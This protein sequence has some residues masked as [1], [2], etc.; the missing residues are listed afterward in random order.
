MFINSKILLIYLPRTY[1]IH[2]LS[3]IDLWKKIWI[4]HAIEFKKR[5]K[6]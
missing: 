3:E 1:F 4:M 6:L 2:L 5:I